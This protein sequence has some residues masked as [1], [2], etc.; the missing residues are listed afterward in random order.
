MM[1][2]RML[3]AWL[4][5]GLV[6]ACQDVGGPAEGP[7][8][9]PV[10]RA[11]DPR[12]MRVLFVGNSLTFFNDLPLRTAETAIRDTALRAP[13]L[14]MVVRPGYSL[15]QHWYLGEAATRIAGER[16]DYVVLQEGS[17]TIL[18]DPDTAA[19]Y[20][21]SFDSL[22]RAHGARTVL[23]LTWT[24]GDLGPAAQDTVTR[25][26][27]QLADQ[28]D[29]LVAPVGIAWQLVRQVRPDLTLYLPDSIHPAPIGTYEA[30]C[31]FV[32]TLWRRTPVGLALPYAAG[33]TSIVL[34]DSAT[35]LQLATIAW[36]A[37]QPYLPGGALP[38]APRAAAR[39]DD[40]PQGTAAAAGGQA[41]VTSLQR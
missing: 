20:V 22:A 18:Q 34:L 6:A 13:D 11:E 2:S 15:R 4:A 5:A 41:I 28:V 7:P 25:H 39:A 24:Y 16:W 23:Y 40:G 37:T 10:R 33:D 38:D 19:R 30:A 26:V 29:A 1:R 36:A 9:V 32:A 21:A 35:V 3:R 17:V 27:L 31:V 14:H 8:P 12:A